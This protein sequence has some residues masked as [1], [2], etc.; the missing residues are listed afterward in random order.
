MELEQAISL[1]QH[2]VSGN[3]T[4]WA[5][6]GCGNGLFTKALAQLL[7]NDSL[8]YAVDKNS[9]ALKQVSVRKEIRLQKISLDFVQAEMPFK[10]LSGILMANAF[11]FV[12]EKHAFISR[13]FNCLDEKGYFVMVEYNTDVANAW[14][15]YPVS[16]NN[17][18][19]FFKSYKWEAKKLNELPSRFGGSMY[20]AIIFK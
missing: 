17:L 12:K 9:N 3:K 8:I 7:A 1:I 10:N 16:F 20:S 13:L 11:H 5:D 15:P 2:P 4:V 19:M 6:L 18:A 14:V